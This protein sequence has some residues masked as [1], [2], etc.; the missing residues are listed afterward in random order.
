MVSLIFL[1]T[2]FENYAIQMQKPKVNI[3]ITYVAVVF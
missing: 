2:Y 1:R 3:K